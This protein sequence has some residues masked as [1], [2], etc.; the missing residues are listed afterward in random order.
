MDRLKGKEL[1]V[2]HMYH[3]DHNENNRQLIYSLTSR[4]TPTQFLTIFTAEQTAVW[5]Q[6]LSLW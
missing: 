6:V 1:P 4:A 5:I 2:Y 3:T